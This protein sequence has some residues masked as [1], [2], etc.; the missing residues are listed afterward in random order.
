MSDPIN[1]T[2]NIMDLPMDPANGGSNM[3]LIAN[4]AISQNVQNIQNTQNNSSVNLDQNTINQ[5]VN[6]LQQATASGATQLRSRDIPMTTNNLTNDM[7]ITP[8]YIPQSVIDNDENDYIRNYQET[9]EII[10]E[11]NSSIEEQNSLDDIY[12]EIQVPILLAVLYFLFQLPF[13]R[14]FLFSYFPILFSKDGNLNLNGYIFM[15]T[16][17]GILYYL[18]NKVNTHFGKF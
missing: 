18:L 1:T 4:E 12:N 11:Y 17:F 16:L 7:G 9:E 6:G 15:S 5:I 8:N 14:K 2:T 13:F 10:K 3:N